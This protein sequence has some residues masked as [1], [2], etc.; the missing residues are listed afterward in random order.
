[1]NMYPLITKPTRITAHSATLLDNIFT[2]ILENSID[3]GLLLNDT[4]DH[5]PVFM[6]YET[7][8]HKNKNSNSFKYKRVITEQL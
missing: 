5:L 8:C 2:N 1:M 3:S 7:N 4:C 6:V